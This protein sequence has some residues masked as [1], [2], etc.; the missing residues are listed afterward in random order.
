MAKNHYV[1]AE[2][3]HKEYELSL[4]DNKPTRKLLLMFEKIAKHYSTKFRGKCKLDVDSCVNYALTE[5][6]LKWKKY[7]K[8]RSNN[9]F[10]FFTKMIANDLTTHHNKIT[11]N[12]NL[13]I[14][15]DALFSNNSSN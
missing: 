11:K 13:H 5:A 4:T 10:A 2:E 9:I 1:K 14:S 8:E 15:L 3:F 12:S 6:W 7:D